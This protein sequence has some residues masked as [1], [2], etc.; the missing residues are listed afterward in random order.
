M[1]KNTI[2]RLRKQGKKICFLSNAP[3]RSERAKTTL[4][5]FGIE[6]QK[7][8]D[9]I[10]T[11]GEYAFQ[12][13]S[14]IKDKDIDYFYFGEDK[15][16]GLLQGLSHRVATAEEADIAI[17]TGLSPH[18]QVVDVTEELDLCLK[19]N[20]TIYC[21]N[22]DKFVHKKDGR[23]HICAGAIAEE[24]AKKGGKVKY[25][26]KPYSGV[27]QAVLNFF[28]DIDKKGYFM[29]WRWNGN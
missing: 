29:Y 7:H 3:R 21:I 18:Q 10:M 1:P 8:Y 26:G 11:S 25:F 23:S 6:Y 20:L 17:S 16:R 2:L 24:Y 13:F 5:S 27:Y 12:Y 15:D 4:A 28:S 19:N 14:N 9:H 22:P